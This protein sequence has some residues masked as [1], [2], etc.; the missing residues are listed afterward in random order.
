MPPPSLAVQKS[1]E[2]D[3][4]TSAEVKT[5]D[6]EAINDE[7]VQAVI[8][9]LQETSNRPHLIKDLSTVLMGQL[10]VVQQYVFSLSFFLFFSFFSFPLFFIFHPHLFLFPHVLLHLCAPSIHPLYPHARLVRPS[11]L[12]AHALTTHVS[13]PQIPARS[14]HPDLPAT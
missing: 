5:I 13:D 14:S 6:L 3:D 10:K 2:K 7:I 9:R 4:S 1:I 12:H 11:F 8:A